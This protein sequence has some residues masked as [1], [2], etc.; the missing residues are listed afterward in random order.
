MTETEETIKILDHYYGGTTPT[1]RYYG[2]CDLIKFW[3]V[4]TRMLVGLRPR[5]FVGG[6]NVR[7]L[8]CSNSFWTG[9]DMLEN[10]AVNPKFAAKLAEPME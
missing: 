5:G 3:E 7:R 9:F 6:T 2:F 8:I 4:D 1:I 10:M